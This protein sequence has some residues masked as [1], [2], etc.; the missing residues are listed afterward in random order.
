M[1]NYLRS[2]KS[3]SSSRVGVALE[4]EELEGDGQ[5]D[6]NVTGDKATNRRSSKTLT[7]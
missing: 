1:Y 7:A 6:G 2:Q 3:S 4:L 5:K